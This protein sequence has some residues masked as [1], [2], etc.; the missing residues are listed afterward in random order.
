[1]RTPSSSAASAPGITQGRELSATELL[2]LR[3]RRQRDVAVGIA[4]VA[5]LGLFGSVSEAFYAWTHRPSVVA[6]HA[7]EECPPPP[8]PPPAPPPVMALPD[9]CPTGDDA[10]LKLEGARFVD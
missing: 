1:M 5:G 6:Y 2:A 8:P 4:I 9:Y 10:E 7:C 3:M